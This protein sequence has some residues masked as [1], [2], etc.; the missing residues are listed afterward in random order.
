MSGRVSKPG[1]VEN[2]EVAV[3]IAWPSVSV[4]KLFPLSV[5]TSGFVGAIRVSDVG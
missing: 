1:M 5:F 2:V 3:G 4:K